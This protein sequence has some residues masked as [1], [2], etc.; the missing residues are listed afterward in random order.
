MRDQKIEIK[1]GISYHSIIAEKF[2]TNLFSVFLA[3]PLTR[4]NVTKNALLVSV[5]R[6]GSK[7][8]PSQEKI[9]QELEEM[10]G[11]EF[12]CGIDKIGD[13]HILKFYLESIKEE[14]LPQ[15]EE[16]FQKSLQ[17]LLEIIFDPYV[18]KDAFKEE[19]VKGEKENIK[20][21]IEGK[22]DNKANY[23]FQK[24]VEEMFKGEPYGLYKYGY[25]EDL[26]KIT[27][28][29]LYQYYKQLISQCKIDIF[30]S[31]T[32]KNE[33]AIDCQKQILESVPGR[34]PNYITTKQ[35]NTNNVIQKEKEIQEQMQITQGK[36]VIGI[37]AQ[38]IRPQARYIGTIYN[39]ILGGGSNSKLFQNVR[40]KASLAYTATSNYI[41][42]KDAIFI[43]CGIEIE[44]YKKSLE[45]IRQQLEDM[46]N[47]K[48][49]EKDIKQAKELIISSISSIQEEQD[50]EITY[51]YGQ[52]L[53]DNFV[54]IEDYQE[55]IQAISKQEIIEFANKIAISVIYFLKN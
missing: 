26:E 18:E 5:L 41:K 22:V 19:Y 47:G 9:S 10:Y 38:D 14:F 29:C 8:M 36:L 45:I 49:E 4:E 53:S 28:Q 11:A 31:G 50:S 55:K 13:N 39:A 20:R 43:R 7:N 24:C 21:I 51:Y 27:P 15:K 46:K 34:K 54:S 37:K 52:E 23:V 2:K 12:D 48:F 42:Q 35:N 3:T 30:I 17:L 16:I 44:N 1:D 25:L 33:V 6:R 32:I 40:E